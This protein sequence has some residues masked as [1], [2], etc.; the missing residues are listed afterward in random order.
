MKLTLTLTLLLFYA[1]TLCHA[2]VLDNLKMI[3]TSDGYTYKGIEHMSAAYYRFA[4]GPQ[5]VWIPV[6]IK[7][8][9]IQMHLAWTA[10]SM[11]AF[12]TWSITKAAAATG[13]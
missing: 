3:A 13:K 11:S 5:E 12:A 1:T 4:N 2:D 10:G 8:D 6:S 7:D 9:W